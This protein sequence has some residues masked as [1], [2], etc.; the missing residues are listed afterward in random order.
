MS[1][2]HEVCGRCIKTCKRPPTH[3]SGMMPDEEYCE[4]FKV[5]GVQVGRYFVT[6]MDVIRD[7]IDKGFVAKVEEWGAS[8]VRGEVC[9]IVGCRAKPAKKCGECN[10]HYCEEHI[11]VH[12]MIHNVEMR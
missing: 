9:G 8:S 12:G 2:I 7:A 10:H 1:E 6:G 5:G 4:G 11:K 3:W